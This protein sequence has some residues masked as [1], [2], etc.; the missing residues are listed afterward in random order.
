MA[1]VSLR[2]TAAALLAAASPD[3]WSTALQA[4][5]SLTGVLRGGINYHQHG[6]LKQQSANYFLRV[7]VGI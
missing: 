6:A 2:C 7:I 4:D 5:G 1:G 3:T